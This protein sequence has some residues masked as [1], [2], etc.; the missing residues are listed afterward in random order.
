MRSTKKPKQKQ[1][2]GQWVGILIY[3]LI[4]AACGFL[5]MMFL[6]EAESAGMPLSALLLSMALLFVA[7]YA[8][9]ALQIAI[10][11]AGHL[12]FGLLTGYRFCS[13]RVFSLMW[14]REGERVRFRRMNIAGTGGQ[15]LMAP[16]DLVDGRMPVML[17]NFGGAILNAVTGLLF[18]GL[19]FL[20]PSRSLG[21]VICAFFAVI[22]FAFALMNGLP[23][24]MGA[25][26]NDGRN[27]LE[28]SRSAE[29]TRAFWIQMKAN[30]E[31]ARGVRLR[32]MP[33][34]WFSVPS[35]EAMQNGI[36]A[37]LGVLACDRLMDQQRFPEADALTARL[38]SLPSGIAGL[39]RNLM[40][41][42]RMYLELIGENRAEVL[43]AMRTDELLKTMKAMKSY[44]SVLRTEYAY[45]LLA[46]RDAE[47]A[48]A[49]EQRFEKAAESFPYPGEIQA[50]REL[51]AL[52][53][54]A[55][56]A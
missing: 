26:N 27:A 7:M 2:A 31:S 42:N 28:L 54:Q 4:G 53:K 49:V 37:A 50:E 43:D 9:M 16:P 47:K 20:F 45:A 30:S 8:A 34:E 29:A 38:L 21:W 39:H 14:I 12:L 11:E 15:C 25:A 1:P 5:I 6:E 33:E 48:A 52:A 41:C 10:H 3:L 40:V 55:K 51:L 46:E 35:D 24:R 32:D 23:L 18:L 44:L 56:A 22:G 19:C 36:T 17:Y 13:Y